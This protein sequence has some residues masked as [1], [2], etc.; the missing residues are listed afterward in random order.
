MYHSLAINHTPAIIVPTPVVETPS[1]AP[2]IKCE[3]L[4]SPERSI[5]AP[6]KTAPACVSL[7]EIFRALATDRIGIVHDGIATTVYREVLQSATLRG[8]GVE[9]LRTIAILQI[10][11]L[12]KLVIAYLTHIVV[13]V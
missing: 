6:I 8:V 7:V 4:I 5:S 12:L 10:C 3:G 13:A 2:F 1:I 9:G 11:A